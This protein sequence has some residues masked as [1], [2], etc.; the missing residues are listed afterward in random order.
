MT[1]LSLMIVRYFYFI[2]IH[3]P[4]YETDAPLIID[5]D[6]KLTFAVAFQYFQSVPCVKKARQWR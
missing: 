4:P 5:S 3:V 2:G 1:H 6:T